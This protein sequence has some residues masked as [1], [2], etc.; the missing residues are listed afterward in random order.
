MLNSSETKATQGGPISANPPSSAGQPQVLIG[1]R[2]GAFLI[3]EELGEGGMGAVFRGRDVALDRPVAIKVLHAK[4]ARDGEFVDRFV[5][6]A[7]T[8]AKLNHP[9][10]VAIYGAGYE[11]GVAYM[12]LELVNGC[13]LFELYRKHRP[14][15]PRRACELIRGVAEGL[16]VAHEAGVVHRDIKP[17]NI[18]INERGVPKLADFGLARPSDSRITETG[19]FLG[20]PQYASP[21]QC[22]A[23][24]LTPASDL[25]SLGV[26]LYELL[27]GRPP[28]EAPTPL[29]LFKK[30]LLEAPVPLVERCPDLSP[31]ALAI[32]E[33]LLRKE[34]GKRY[35]SARELARDLG[36]ALEGLPEPTPAED[37]LTHLSEAIR[38]GVGAVTVSLRESEASGRATPFQDSS[39]AF[40]EST[41]A[42]LVLPS[43]TAAA[44]VRAAA[45]AVGEDLDAALERLPSSPGE[46]RGGDEGS[47]RRIGLALALV[48]V[49]LAAAI[50][51]ALRSPARSGPLQV[52]VLPFKNGAHQADYA[53][54]SE[55]IPEFVTGQLG[56]QRDLQLAAPADVTAAM[57]EDFD[58]ANP[59]RRRAL[60]VALGADFVVTGRFYAVGERVGVSAVVEDAEGTPIRIADPN[61]TLFAKEEVLDQLNGLAQRIASTLARR[62][63]PTRVQGA[64]EPMPA[65]LAK[66][67]S[68]DLEADFVGAPA[69]PEPPARAEAE[70][71]EA[72]EPA[73]QS[74]QRF[75][76]GAREEL[77]S[78]NEVRRQRA[79]AA[80]SEGDK[81]EGAGKKPAASA[82]AK[83]RGAAAPAPA[84]SG[85]PA[86][87]QA[88]GGNEDPS[89]RGA[90]GRPRAPSAQKETIAGADRD[91][92]AED[93]DALRDP[94]LAKVEAAESFWQLAN[95]ADELRACGDPACIRRA[96]ERAEQEFKGG[97]AILRARIGAR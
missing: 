44:E 3:E 82:G 91:E 94:L 6:E 32:V 61:P 78:L 38:T 40:A 72:S 4:L 77:G 80:K 37:P 85:D 88:P 95:L 25:Y 10:T 50:G 81:S 65:T 54:L 20:T 73:P 26:V 7:R 75:A 48:A 2:L 1:K 86:A 47:L 74:A 22:N 16:A 87:Q 13:S 29:T 39:A 31:S 57:G 64:D 28:Y 41:A 55:A 71:G 96:I 83:L 53:W 18:L 33:R 70:E 97:V 60:L 43:E 79:E 8:A 27:A 35:Q 12:A 5:R 34:P 90:A 68:R 67:D 63:R 36:R 9:N 58:P 49:L 45:D 17:E 30:I 51:V 89:D 93:A 14:F 56:Q 11:D 66:A 84:P 42:P 15:P 21:E 92:R 76:G 24:E 23:S 46:P 69:P 52:V 59:G 19:V 62:A